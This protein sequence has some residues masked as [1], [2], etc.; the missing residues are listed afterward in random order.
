MEDQTMTINGRKVLGLKATDKG[1]LL[2][3][4]AAGAEGRAL[5]LGPQISADDLRKAELSALFWKRI[6]TG[7]LGLI[8]YFSATTWGVFGFP[9]PW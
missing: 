7:L 3:E 1:T 8:A 6:A 5:G 4:V 2:I 9:L